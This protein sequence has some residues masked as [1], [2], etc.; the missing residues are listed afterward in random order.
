MIELNIPKPLSAKKA[1]TPISP[2]NCKN[3]DKTPVD[4]LGDPDK[5]HAW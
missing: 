3:S 5:T 4:E 2:L 1:V